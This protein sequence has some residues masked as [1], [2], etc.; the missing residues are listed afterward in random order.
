LGAWVHTY[1]EAQAARGPPAPSRKE[2]A[3]GSQMRAGGGGA[4]K[5]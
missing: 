5:V 1:T 4:L 3:Q 2:P